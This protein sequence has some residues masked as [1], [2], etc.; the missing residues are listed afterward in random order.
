M[1]PGDIV[2]I[3]RISDPEFWDSEADCDGNDPRVY[4][5][6]LGILRG[7]AEMDMLDVEFTRGK[8]DSF[9]PEELEVV[10]S[11]EATS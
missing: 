8:R 5:G 10:K 9:W 4:E 6:R 3:T 1:K 2:R 11:S 7:P